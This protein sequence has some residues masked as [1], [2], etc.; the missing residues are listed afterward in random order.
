MPTITLDAGLAGITGASWPRVQYFCTWRTGGV[1]PAPWDSLNLGLHVGDA[2]EAVQA[3]R[4]RLR[5]SL[6]AEPLW[7][8]QVHGTEVCDAD[9]W[10]SARTPCADAAVTTRTGRPLAIMTADC[11]PVVLADE[12]GSVLGLAHAGWRG[13]AA[14]VLEHTL[15]VMRR[16][17][18]QAGEWRAWIGPAIGTEAFEVGADVYRAFVDQDAALAACFT[19]QPEAGRWHA[20]LAGLA[21][22]RLARAG[23]T[24]IESSGACTCRQAD[25]YFSYRRDGQTG[26]QATL[27]WLL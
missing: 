24:R 6:P 15:Q 12:A 8:D 2:P 14:G 7:L 16:R 10:Q 25:R 1:S 13:L 3:N 11:L 19:A 23:V 17:A 18:P 5:R 21:G 27:A 9:T 20:D 4:D 22:A 26:R